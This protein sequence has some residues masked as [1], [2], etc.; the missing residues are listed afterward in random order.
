MLT[1]WLD[2]GE[3]KRACQDDSYKKMT[4]FISRAFREAPVYKVCRF[5][6]KISLSLITDLVQWFTAFPQIVSR[7]GHDNTEVYKHLSALIV[8]VMQAYPLQALWLFTSVIKSTKTN[9]EARGRSIL[10]Q[11]QVCPDHLWIGE[12]MPK[13]SYVQN[14]PHNHRN[15]I[16]NLIQQSNSM[17]NELLGLCDRHVEDGK[18][19]LSMGKDFPK[20]KRIG[21]CD[22]IIP[23]QESLTA[24]L[25]P[26][27]ETE[28][29]HY[30]FPLDTPTFQGEMPFLITYSLLNDNSEFTDE[31]EVMRSLAKPRKI[32]IRGSNGQT[33]M[34]LGKPRDDLR[35]DA[36]LMDLNAIINK[37]L[38]G[39]SES[40]K[41]QLRKP[42]FKL[43][44]L[45]I[46]DWF[47]DIRTY[48]VV[49]LNEECG[50]IQWVPNTT[51]IRPILNKYYDARRVKNWV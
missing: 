15:N 39:N 1:I 44:W 24:S 7:V 10:S 48:G 13:P 25:P 2:V 33:Y 6:I 28:S 34:F 31:I 47:T 22:L 17:T 42:V 36:R 5:F 27:P 29:K 35:K 40:R 37:L 49:T 21:H 9:R 11:L 23:L 8:I 46:T 51:P 3:D 38:K 26:T 16:Q 14:N 45:R 43:D 18:Y 41:R 20:L 50:F 12:R 19:M 32:T 30:P 4:D